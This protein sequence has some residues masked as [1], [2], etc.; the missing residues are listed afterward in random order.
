[1]QDLTISLDGPKYVHD[2]YRVTYNGQGTHSIIIANLEN[3]FK[4]ISN[5]TDITLSP[6]LN[7][8]MKR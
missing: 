8:N 5:L 2:E 4:H 6:T 1:M 3:H 7:P